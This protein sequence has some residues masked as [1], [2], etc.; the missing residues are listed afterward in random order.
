M[1]N[2]VSVILFR[3]IHRRLLHNGDAAQP[4]PG[5]HCESSP[6]YNCTRNPELFSSVHIEAIEAL[7]LQ[8][9]LE[10]RQQCEIARRQVRCVRGTR[11][12]VLFKLNGGCHLHLVTE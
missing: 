4:M 10:T 8:L 5:K 2:N 6:N 9:F 11:K 7:T 1:N 12:N 3:N